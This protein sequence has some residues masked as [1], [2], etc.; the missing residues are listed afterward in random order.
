MLNQEQFNAGVKK[1]GRDLPKLRNA[2][3][4]LCLFALLQSYNRNSTQAAMLVES[5]DGRIIN[6]SAVTAF[7]E[8]FGHLEA[9]KN[10]ETGKRS[11]KFKEKADVAVLTEAEL[12]A[13]PMWD[14]FKKPTEKAVENASEMLARLVKRLEKLA[15][16]ELLDDEQLDGAAFGQEGRT[17]V[18]TLVTLLHASIEEA[19][20]DELKAQAKEKADEPIRKV[21]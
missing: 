15:K 21:A 18:R 1:L 7:L 13:L 3:Q 2:V 19:K 11:M 9:K 14:A 5:I 4:A 10:K 12:E 20:A 17:S 16:D 6:V 8:H